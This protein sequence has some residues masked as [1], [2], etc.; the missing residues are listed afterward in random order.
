VSNHRVLVVGTYPPIPLPAAATT[1]EVVRR[2]WA[3]GEQVTVVSPR[4][5]AAHL[6]VPVAGVLAGRRLKQLH[7][8]TSADR[9]VVVLE[10]GFPLPATSGRRLANRLEQWEAVRSLS[11]AFACFERVTLVRVGPL[12]VPPRLEAMLAGAGCEVVDHPGGE[13]GPPGVTPLGHQQ[14][15]PAKRLTQVALSLARRVL[16]PLIA[17][18]RTRLRA[19]M[20]R[21]QATAPST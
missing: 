8:R 1:V 20:R 17:P 7:R 2:A 15:G 18:V 10:R 12:D 11:R 3:A 9:A 19:L 4:P 14:A 21:H 6:V 5:S 13:P 16:G